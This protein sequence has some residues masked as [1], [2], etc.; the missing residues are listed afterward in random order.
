MRRSPFADVPFRTV[1][2]VLFALSFVAVV[3]LTFWSGYYWKEKAETSRQAITNMTYA[4]DVSGVESHLILYYV[5]RQYEIERAETFTLVS[6]QYRDQ[7]LAFNRS[8]I[9]DVHVGLSDRE[10]DAVLAFSDNIEAATTS[11]DTDWFRLVPFDL[12]KSLDRRWIYDGLRQTN[13]DSSLYEATDALLRLQMA[14]TRN[15][16]RVFVADPDK[17]QLAEFEASLLPE[18]AL[19]QN[20]VLDRPIL[21][22][23]VDDRINQAFTALDQLSNPDVPYEA[24][25]VS[26]IAFY[27]Q[28]QRML[29]AIS[30]K[31]LAALETE[32]RQE[33]SFY[34]FTL[35]FGML[36]LALLSYGFVRYYYHY[37]FD[38]VHLQERALAI[39]PMLEPPANSFPDRHDFAPVEQ[40]LKRIARDMSLTVRH[41]EAKSFE[42]AEVH[43]RWA[44][45][46]TE[47]GLAIAL[48]DDKFE[49]IERNDVFERLLGN[50]NLY[51]FTQL[52]TATGRKIWEDGLAH[53]K[54]EQRPSE[55]ILFFE[56]T[57]RRYMSVKLLP[58]EVGN[59]RHYYIILEDVTER[60][61]R[62]QEVDRLV[63]YDDATGLLNAYGFAQTYRKRG[64]AATHGVFLVFKVNDYQHLSDWYGTAYAEA[65]LKRLVSRL[66]ARLKKYAMSLLG[67]YRDNTLLLYIQDLDTEDKDEV[68]DLFP[69][70]WDERTRRQA[71]DSQCGMTVVRM[72]SYDEALKQAM[73]ALQLAIEQRTRFV[74]YDADVL[75]QVERLALI[76]RALPYAIKERAIHV[77]YHPQIE[78]KTGG[79]VGAEALARW[80]SDTHGKIS[81]DEFIRI[82]EKSDQILWLSLSV[83][84]QVIE[85]LLRWHD[86]SLSAL[87]VSYNLSPR[88]LD[89]AIVDLLTKTAETHPWITD[90]LVIELTESSDLLTYPTDLSQLETIARNGYRLS[91]DDFGTG[92]ASFEAIWHLPIHEVKI[93]RMYVSG[94]AKDS[95]S[96]LRAVARFT[97]EQRLVLV[98]E[99]IETKLELKRMIEEG[100]EIGQGYY[101]TEPLDAMTFTAWA[102]ERIQKDETS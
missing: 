62:E 48:I 80:D 7:A 14:Y 18:Q 8:L 3:L 98:A 31:A 96:F 40:E 59:H 65:A 35:I 73:N 101:F 76:E 94:K 70:D 67:R 22:D 74:W 84:E 63:R 56:E 64:L 86:T 81:P 68:E 38:L 46:F 13:Q 97:R 27:D 26:A 4:K 36:T 72:Q 34:V 71:L 9:N 5:A 52:L 90:R 16:D 42:L 95:L 99:G 29:D 49:I 33:Q 58:L 32:R 21:S 88:C 60:I 100:V 19:L 85:Q 53:V 78:L 1:L 41:L 75:R 91:I 23:T 93:D 30:D 39:D 82:A 57:P 50:R 102:E 77:A 10:R 6:D 45:L 15:I 47:T 61:V 12:L 79:I 11:I 54:R 55:F 2:T 17:D 28:T 44:S 43:E 20:L 83:L 24:R 89:A 69:R 25:Y 87:T 92:Y 51:E 37:R 66:E